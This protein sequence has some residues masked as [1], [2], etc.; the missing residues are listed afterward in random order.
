MPEDLVESVS[1]CNPR[2]SHRFPSLGLILFFQCRLSKSSPRWSQSGHALSRRCFLIS[3]SVPVWVTGLQVMLLG[4]LAAGFCQP[5]YTSDEIL[6]NSRIHPEQRSKLLS[7]EQL[8]LLHHHT[9]EICRIAVSVNA[10]DSKFPE[11]WL[12]KHRWVRSSSRNGPA[13][14]LHHDRGK[15]RKRNMH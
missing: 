9:S 6:Y 5:S 4:C 2:K 10:D 14:R 11:H 7:M 1:G 3:H 13:K 12:F 8:T 15:A